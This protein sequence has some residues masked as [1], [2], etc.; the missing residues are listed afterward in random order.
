MSELTLKERVKLAQNLIKK[1][2]KPTLGEIAKSVGFS[3]TVEMD[4]AFWEV[5]D[6]GC[7]DCER[8]DYDVT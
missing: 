1:T 7:A 8:L 5:L 4:D 3:D 6:Y 2:N